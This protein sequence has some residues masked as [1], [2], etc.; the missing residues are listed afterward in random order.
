MEKISRNCMHL[1]LRVKD[2]EA[3][4]A[5]YRDA[6]GFEEIFTLLMRDFYETMELS[7]DCSQSQIERW[8]TMRS[9]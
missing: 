6:L 1:G 7:A 5:F 3:T 4:M 9:G 2:Y 8:M